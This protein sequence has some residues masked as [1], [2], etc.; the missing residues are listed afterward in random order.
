MKT[1]GENNKVLE[2]NTGKYIYDH[3]IGKDILKRTQSTKHK[4]QYL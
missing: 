1:K 3:R 2:E 4:R